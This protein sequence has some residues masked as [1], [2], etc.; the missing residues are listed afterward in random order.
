MP[1]RIIDDGTICRLDEQTFYVTTTSSGAGAVYEWFSWWLADWRMDVRLTDVTQALSAVNLAGPRRARSSG[2]V[3]DLDCSAEGFTYLDGKRAVVA[4]V[5]VPDP[6]DRLRGRGRLRDPLPVRPRRAPLGDAPRGGR[7]A[8]PAPVRARAATAPAAAEAARAGRPG[9]RLRVDPVRRGMPWIVKLDKEEDFIGTWALEQAGEGPP[10]TALV[11][12][13]AARRPGADRG[14][15][16][17]H[18]NGAGPVGQVTSARYSP[19]LGGVI[20]MAWVPAALAED[21]AVVTIS[22]DGRT[23][24]ATVHGPFYDPEGEVL[25]S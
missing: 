7:G 15:R 22:D 21:G 18:A 10:E 19:Q 13:H 2:A 17:A 6:A 24:S 16:R 12:L 8:R 3:T 1:G 5:P 9:H 23:L 14:R 4:G 25:R 11:G 20:G